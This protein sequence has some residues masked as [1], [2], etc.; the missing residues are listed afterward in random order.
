MEIPGFDINYVQ[1]RFGGFN[2]ENLFIIKKLLQLAL[3]ELLSREKI[4]FPHLLQAEN[5]SDYFT[6][7]PYHATININHIY[8][9]LYLQLQFLME[10]SDPADI[11]SKLLAPLGF[12]VI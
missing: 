5:V 4:L 11:C 9:A 7:T 1:H 6:A 3:I 2:N 8:F 12:H 10:F